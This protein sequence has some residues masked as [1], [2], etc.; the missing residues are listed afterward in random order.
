MLTKEQFFNNISD[1]KQR[2]ASMVFF[3]KNPTLLTSILM[4][5]TSNSAAINITKL[6]LDKEDT[7]GITLFAT[8]IARDL[9]SRMTLKLIDKKTSV[10]EK[11]LTVTFADDFKTVKVNWDGNTITKKEK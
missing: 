9:K 10:S 11:S 3:E 8:A 4:A 5:A 1:P 6:M 7:F 2:E